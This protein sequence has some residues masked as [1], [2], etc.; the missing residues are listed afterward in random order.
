MLIEQKSLL[1]E[2][3]KEASLIVHKEEFSFKSYSLAIPMSLSV[4]PLPLI[5]PIYLTLSL[6]HI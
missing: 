4:M 1:L 6:I 5:D 2:M 3:S